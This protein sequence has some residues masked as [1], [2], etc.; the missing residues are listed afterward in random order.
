MSLV[1]EFERD[2]AEIE[3]EKAKLS[4]IEQMRLDSIEKMRSAE[5]SAARE[6][7]ARDKEIAAGIQN[8]LVNPAIDVV[9]GTKSMEDAFKEMA[10]N[11]LKMLSQI[12]LL[13]AI[14]GLTGGAGSAGSGVP[15][16]PALADGGILRGGFKAL[17]KGGIAKR[18]TLGLIGE[19]GQNEA[20]V[21]L[22]DGKSIPVDMG[23]GSGKTENIFYINAI[24]SKSFV[25]LARRNPEAIIR[26]LTE[27]IE[28]GN[29]GLRQNLKKAVS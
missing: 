27:Q 23:E 17:A 21:P 5:E 1:F 28:K 3:A 20:V 24:D 7:L 15:H 11:V 2:N 12:I 10:V 29:K 13:K 18:P 16:I 25:E 19:G 26:P 9:A 8:Y 6:K 22:P 14:A 4:E